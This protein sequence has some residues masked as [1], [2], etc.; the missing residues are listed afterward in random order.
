VK[1]ITKRRYG[2]AGAML[3]IISLFQIDQR[4]LAQ[5]GQPQPA[6]REKKESLEKRMALLE[7]ALKEAD[8][9]RLIE[10]RAYVYT[11]AARLLAASDAERSVRLL[12]Q[13]YEQIVAAIFS[14]NRE[15]PQAEP[16]MTELEQSRRNIIIQLSDLDPLRALDLLQSF[17]K[18]V[19]DGDHQQM[20]S[21]PDKEF[22][23]LVLSKAARQKPQQVLNLTLQK[24][25]NGLTPEAVAIYAALKANDAKLAEQLAQAMAS[26]TANEK[27]D[28]RLPAA[29]AALLL[30]TSLRAG[31]GAAGHFALDKTLLDESSLKTLTGFVADVLLA[32]FQMRPDAMAPAELEAYAAAI[33]PYA[34]A[35]AQ[36][37]QACAARLREQTQ[38]S[39][40]EEFYSLLAAKSY[41]RALEAAAGAPDDLRQ[42]AFE[43]VAF[44][45]IQSGDAARARELLNQR[46]TD[47]AIR[48]RLERQLTAS[49]AQNA[50]SQGNEDAVR[51][52]TPQLA[53][54][55]Q[56]LAALLTLASAAAD[57]GD[58]ERAARIL[59]EA[60]QL[61]SSKQQQLLDRL[62]I[63]NIAFKVNP[64]SGAEMLDAHLDHLNA[65]ISAAAT[66]DGYFAQEFMRDDEFKYLN[67]SPLIDVVMATVQTIARLAETDWERAIASANR[68]DR[69]ELRTLAKMKLAELLLNQKPLSH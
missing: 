43:Q 3:L 49:E 51:R 35:K 17:P 47:S 63:I 65:L 16:S 39:P 24:L 66:L 13:A 61:P 22:E 69:P 37:L 67:G 7:D 45:F 36:R 41:D 46:I 5:T 12:N 40:F 30:L 8:A 21:S 68:F 34:A 60:R 26:R 52:L 32:Q 4:S 58:R 50:A 27:A 54:G 38:T 33:A 18:M 42:T 44:S 56:R 59:A 9:L 11:T 64:A 2:L 55:E 14:I 25:A 15:D 19:A 62:A 23:A 48:E 10:N 53:D 6:Q 29:Q 28:P 1:K 20:S 57:K 31:D